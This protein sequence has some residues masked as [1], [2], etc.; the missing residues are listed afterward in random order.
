MSWNGLE[1][2]AT[3]M[4]QGETEVPHSY[5]RKHMGWVWER[6]N[7]SKRLPRTVSQVQEAGVEANLWGSDMIC[8]ETWGLQWSSQAVDWTKHSIYHASSPRCSEWLGISA[9]LSGMLQMKRTYLTFCQ[10]ET[11]QEMGDSNSSLPFP[12]FAL[13]VNITSVI[14]FITLNLVINCHHPILLVSQYYWL[15]IPLHPFTPM[16]PSHKSQELV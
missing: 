12:L 2:E 8:R 15:H 6:P 1:E 9:E 7:S 11:W 10:S 5:L 4:K 14:S 13:Q 3:S 16:S